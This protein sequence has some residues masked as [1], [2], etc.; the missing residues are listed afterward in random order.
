MYISGIRIMP[1]YCGMIIFATV[2]R[3]FS[4]ITVLITLSLIGIIVMQVS[5]L[6]N[7]IT[8]KEDQV[9]QNI[10]NV[11]D[12]LTKE[13]SRLR[14]EHINAV[15]YDF[16]ALFAPRGYFDQVSIGSKLS[17]DSIN[18]II[19]RAFNNAGLEK[20]QYEYAFLSGS[21]LSYN[22]TIEK[23]SPNFLTVFFDTLVNY[24]PTLMPI[25]S[26]SGSVSESIAKDETLILTVMNWR[27][28]VK[29]PVVWW[30]LLAV[31]FTVIIVSTFY[32]TVH[33]ML[34]QKKLGDIKNDFINNMT[35]EFKT[36]IATISLAVDALKNERVMTDRN[37]MEYFSGIIKEENQRMNK[38][39]E[40]ILKASQFEK[41][42]AEIELK[43]L[44]VHE[45]IENVVDNFQLQ[46]HNKGG[47]AQL[48]LKAAKDVIN[49]DEVHF[50]NLV[51]N[52][53]DNAVK[54]SKD[55]VP[56]LIKVSTYNTGRNIAIRVE[57][58]GIGMSRETQK[59]IFEKFY[60]AH[61]GNLHNVKGF[62]LGLNYVKSVADSHYGA[63]KVESV[64]GKGST[65]IVELPLL[66]H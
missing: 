1:N 19:K 12:N 49:G 3:L 41:E 56:I 6:K 35:H 27:S 50:T 25:R 22:G 23:Q 65:F 29:R 51:N 2:K 43:P 62:G 26:K 15:N 28:F 48:L 58:N 61:T 52:L 34:K 30:I 11:Y 21:L 44:S 47:D 45:A 4:S 8:L 33:T 36:P 57:D 60:R 14:D 31:L 53:I 54:Y 24:T 66:Q 9:K 32:L 42:E 20:M 46:L 63:V 5:W 38:Q 55:N 17:N 39:V 64:L 13:F 59:R 40:T 37:K 16:K 18:N 10:D 7:L